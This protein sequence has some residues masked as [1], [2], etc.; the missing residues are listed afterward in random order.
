MINQNHTIN[1]TQT[2][3]VVVELPPLPWPLCPL[4]LYCATPLLLGHC[5]LV[6]R[7]YQA[8]WL[9]HSLLSCLL[10]HC[11]VPL[12]LSGWLFS[13]SDSST[14]SSSSSSCDSSSSDSS[15]SYS[16]TSDSSSSNYSSLRFLLSPDSY[17]SDSSSSNS[18]SS[19]HS[20]SGSSSSNYFSSDS[21][22]SLVLVGWLIVA[23]P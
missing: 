7:L 4:P 17:S 10:S 14:A 1:T 20:S 22:S 21:S 16:S 3:F 8:G 6:L 15:S 19:D 18:S 11:V 23:L 5:S 12:S 13:S 2:M 9:L